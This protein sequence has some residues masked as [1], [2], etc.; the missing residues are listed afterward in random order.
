MDISGSMPSTL[1]NK[2]LE[3][4][5]E[6]IDLQF[7]FTYNEYDFLKKNKQEEIKLFL[8]LR[9]EVL[10]RYIDQTLA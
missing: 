10:T 4:L 6:A 2:E 1:S 3:N 7:L 9:N 5:L 8:D